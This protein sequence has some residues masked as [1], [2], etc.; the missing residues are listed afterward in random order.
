MKASSVCNDV[1]NILEGTDQRSCA[2]SIILGDSG[3]F[4]HL[5]LKKMSHFTSKEEIPAAD[6]LVRKR[7]DILPQRK[8]T[9]NDIGDKSASI[10]KPTSD[11]KILKIRI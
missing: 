6:K 2:V 5:R 9:Y 10:Q 1:W 7:Y 11:E 3:K 8:M 4:R